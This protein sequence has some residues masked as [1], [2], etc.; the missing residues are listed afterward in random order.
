MRRPKVKPPI[1]GPKAQA[2]IAH[3][4]QSQSIPPPARDYPLVV[5]RGA[6][7]WINDP[8]DNE[9]LDLTGASGECPAGHCHP[10]VVAAVK[11]QCNELLH[12][13]GTHGYCDVQV[14]LARRLGSLGGVHGAGPLVQF[15]SSGSEAIAGAIR[16]AREKTER[17]AVIPFHGALHDGVLAT[18][19]LANSALLEGSGLGPLLSGIH[20]ATY[21]DPL[22]HGPE[23]TVIALENIGSILGK[24]ISPEQVAAFLIDPIQM[25][26]GCIVPPDDFLAA[27]RR[28][29]DQYGILLIFDETQIGIG[30]TGKTFAWQ[31]SEVA[32]DL[33]CLAGGMANGLPLAAIVAASEVMPHPPDIRSVYKGGNPL[34]CTAAL[35][36]LDLLEQGLLTKAADM[37]AR[38]AEQLT[39]VTAEHPHV[40]GLRSRGLLLALELVTDRESMDAAPKLRRQ[41]VRGCLDRGLLVQNSGPSA[42]RLNPPLTLNDDEATVAV[43]ILTAALNDLG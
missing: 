4:K 14:R 6:G 13:S 12:T 25:D 43:E 22:K 31:H 11:R 27:L 15:Y 40:G 24:I 16:V 29:C 32:P 17:P 36:T 34:S 19:N 9:F 28:L 20:Q 38:L 21:P 42:V 10:E 26:N 18:M 5:Q 33:L 23:A 3:S 2:I 8:D 41:V 30:R 37:G 35:T 7:C 1:P 39:A